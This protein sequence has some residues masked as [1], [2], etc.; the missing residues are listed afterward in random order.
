MFEAA[1]EHLAY[2][3]VYFTQKDS[4]LSRNRYMVNAYFRSLIPP[5]VILNV[6]NLAFIIKSNLVRLLYL[7]YLSPLSGIRDLKYTSTDFTS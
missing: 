6:A 5:T 3:N 4:T 7:V 2:H 1:G